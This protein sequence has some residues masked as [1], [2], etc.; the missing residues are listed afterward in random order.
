[1]LVDDDMVSYFTDLDNSSPMPPRLLREH[2]EF[3]DGY[4]RGPLMKQELEFERLFLKNISLKHPL[5]TRTL[6]DI[7]RLHFGPKGSIQMCYCQVE[8]P[9]TISGI[10]KEFSKGHV[11]CSYRE[12]EFGGVF[13]KRCVKKLGVEKV[14]RWYC[15]AC[16]KQMK[17]LACRTL[18][19]VHNDETAAVSVSEKRFAEKVVAKM[20]AKPDAMK[21]FKSRLQELHAGD[22]RSDLEIEDVD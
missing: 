5:T 21:R 18:G 11:S 10:R 22:M 8:V 2:T 7:Q 17:A 14:S 9:C 13:H 3:L 1:M 19:V 6:Q 12:C 20:L 4:D 15:T 16:E